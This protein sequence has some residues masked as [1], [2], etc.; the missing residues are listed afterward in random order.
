MKMSLAS[1]ASGQEIWS[2]MITISHG[3]KRNDNVGGSRAT[4]LER[5]KTRY[6]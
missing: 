4:W 5:H 3:T 1:A 6:S 2:C